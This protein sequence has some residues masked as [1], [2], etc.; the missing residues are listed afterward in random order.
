V[1]LLMV[2]FHLLGGSRQ[3]GTGEDQG[4]EGEKMQSAHV[5]NS[6]CFLV[7]SCRVASVR[8]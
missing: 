3:P 7:I 8:E 4:C 6:L 5:A 2:M 1:P